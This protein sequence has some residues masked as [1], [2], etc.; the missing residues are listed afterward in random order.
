MNSSKV[1]L[2]LKINEILLS[3]RKISGTAVVELA[4]NDSGGED[5]RSTLVKIRFW[6]QC[7]DIRHNW[8]VDR[9]QGTDRVKKVDMPVEA[10]SLSNSS[11]RN[12]NLPYGKSLELGG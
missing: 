12:T 9:R 7:I 2:I 8:G 11:R 10:R 5:C 3:T 6:I 4:I 1:L